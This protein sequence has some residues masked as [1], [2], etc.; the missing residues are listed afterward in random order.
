MRRLGV[1]GW[2]V[3]H[4]RSPA[5]QNAALAELGL[6]DWHYQRLPV[7]PELFAETTRALGPAGF[8]GA[9]VTIPH[10]RAALLLAS[11]ASAAA[12]GDRRRQHAHVHPRRRDR[13]GEH[14]RSRLHRRA[15]G[16]RAGHASAGARRGRERPRGDLGAARSRRRR[17]LRLE[18][19][20]RAGLALARGVRG[21]RESPR[22]RPRTCSS[23]AP[24]SASAPLPA[25]RGA[26][27]ARRAARGA[28]EGPEGTQSAPA[29]ELSAS[30]LRGLNQVGLTFDQVGEYANVVDLVYTSHTTD[31]LAAA[32]AHGA[33]TVDGLEILVAQ[34]A[35]SLEMWT[36]RSPPLAGHAQRRP[37]RIDE[38][39]RRAPK[40]A[41]HERGPEG[42]PRPARHLRDGW[43]GRRGQQRHLGRTSHG[44]TT[45]TATS[46][47]EGKQL[48]SVEADLGLDGRTASTATSRRWKLANGRAGADAD[49]EL[50]DRGEDE[51]GRRERRRCTARRPTGPASRAHPARAPHSAS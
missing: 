38:R 8:V 32:G 24:R 6:A 35:L 44:W 20:P 15:R 46:E 21:A 1:L 48:Q 30:E 11:S 49:A 36:G 12:A 3:S 50:R 5:M 14:G 37:R 45:W 17:G 47:R 25:S 51:R 31:L 27:I 7:P 42:G 33:H 2:P 26:R 19:D 40:A 4:S 22:R 28:E 18:P 41:R 34:G 39:R 16:S 29:V 13:G 10:K 43:R 23:T 9:N